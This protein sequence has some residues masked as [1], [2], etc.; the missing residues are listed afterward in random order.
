MLVTLACI[1]AIYIPVMYG[2]LFTFSLN[3]SAL[4]DLTIFISCIALTA[5]VF[6]KPKPAISL[7]SSV[8]VLA[9]SIVG[10]FYHFQDSGTSGP[11]PYEWLNGYYLHTLPL[12]IIVTFNYLYQKNEKST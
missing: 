7:I 5:T 11:L 8:I 12:L 9:F 1:W 10:F 2:L 6:I 3:S 4:V